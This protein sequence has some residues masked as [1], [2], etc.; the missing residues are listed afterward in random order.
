[1]MRKLSSG[2]TF[3][4][5]L[6]TIL[7]LGSFTATVT[8][9]Q[10]SNAETQA[11]PAQTVTQA[12]AS[13]S[14]TQTQPSEEPEVK[15]G[16]E[17]M[18]AQE[19]VNAEEFV[20][21]LKKVEE[22]L[23]LFGYD[24]FRIDVSKLTP[25]P[26]VRDTYVISPGD[27]LML[28]VW[29]QLNMRYELE[30]TPD[31][32]VYIPGISSA[33]GGATDAS[34]EGAGSPDIGRVY[35]GAQTLKQAEATITRELSNLYSTYI[36]SDNPSS[37]SAHVE[38]TPTH[39][40]EVR[41]LVQGEVVHPG[42][43]TLHPSLA[44]LIYALAQAGGVKD[45]GSL[46]RIRIRRADQTISID[47]YDFLLKGTADPQEFQIHANDVI[48]VP[49]KTK[50]VTIQGEVR[51]PARY[52]ALDSEGLLDLVNMA[53]GLKPTASLEKSL[54]LRTQLNEG[55]QT[56]DINLKQVQESKQ[57]IALHDQDIVNIVPSYLLR[58][59]YVSVQGQG[60][61]LPGEY[62]L[63]PG[64]KVR[65]LINDAGGL[66]GEAYLPRAEL[67]RTGRDFIRRYRN[68]NLQR[69]MDGDTDNNLLLENLDQL[70]I[71]T[72][73]E[74][75]GAEGEVTL[76]GHVKSPGKFTLYQG[77]H[78]YD[79]LFA[80]GGFEDKDFLARTYAARGDILRLSDDGAS[81]KL[82][83]FNLE[84]L[85]KGD[86]NENIA[87]RKDDEIVIYSAKEVIGSDDV[88]K[89]SGHVKHP[90][91]FTLYKGMKLSDLLDVN[92]GFQDREFRKLTFLDRGD[93][94]RWVRN[95]EQLERKL[96][97]FN[98]GALL[99]GDDSQDQVLEPNDEIVVYAAKDFLIPK[100]VSIDGFVKKPGVYEY[101]ANMTLGDLLV[102]AGGLREGAYA[103][104]EISRMDADSN[105]DIKK[106]TIQVELDESFFKSDEK[107]GIVLKNNDRVF[108]RKHPKYEKQAVVQ[109]VGEVNFP[110]RYVLGDQERI[111]DL[112]RRAG[113]LKEGAYL[114]AARL[115]R[116][117]P[118]AVS[119]E[120]DDEETKEG[121]AETTAEE[122]SPG[123]GEK[124][125]QEL[126]ELPASR[127]VF[128]LQQALD[129]PGKAEDLTLFDGDRLLIPR[130]ENVVEVK[131]AVTK[132][133]RLACVPGKDVD[134]YIEQ[135]GGF[136]KEA[137]RK[138]VT[139]LYPD[140]REL[141]PSGFLWFG[142]REIEPMCV[143]NVPATSYKF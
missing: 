48:F 52:E 128:D 12:P 55:L 32:Y 104:A 137:D 98:L 69:V 62:Q 68:V 71:Y 129:R 119:P 72:V 28:R 84:K 53:G 95:G 57:F 133:V 92:A 115:F 82:V 25:G 33:A 99:L 65:D 116:R 126:Q 94:V 42:T 88:V 102:Q 40:S 15:A 64:M 18:G 7:V 73:R 131:G 63:R 117:D 100:T 103:R 50:E 30:V 110:G 11:A 56:I 20:A 138:G 13:D 114:K 22:E 21:K 89:L 101:A 66:T 118:K 135:A 122:T 124:D 45:S 43:Y 142:K 108:V 123:D 140:G 74:I 134:Y 141:K 70:V 132:E 109:I 85:L 47:F 97:R 9:A 86:P 113:G 19:E 139:I 1:M 41:F 120:P 54:I 6:C 14:A 76:K 67:I 17:V 26:I 59:D 37:S 125:S 39:V 83:K 3:L 58:V 24:A 38:L 27:K 34:G 127:I 111:S 112:I 46:R 91:E 77:M 136:Q 8:L 93:L 121:T 80:K 23:P 78:L 29:G 60:I 16:T 4:V 5:Y 130:F 10:S 31:L 36:N 90:G 44:N 49:L 51:R 96:I 61:T 75:E 87:L 143:I 106:E 107:G 35:L 2:L 81:R 79:L 105:P